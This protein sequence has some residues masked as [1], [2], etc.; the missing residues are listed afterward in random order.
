MPIAEYIFA[1]MLV[2][3][4]P[5][6]LNEEVFAKYYNELAKIDE[7]KIREGDEIFWDQFKR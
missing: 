2:G 6:M 5:F 4:G 3:V 7:K 1:D